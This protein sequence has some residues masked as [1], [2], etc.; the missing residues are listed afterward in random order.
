MHASTALELMPVVPVIAVFLSVTGL[1]QIPDERPIRTDLSERVKESVLITLEPRPPADRFR[2][3]AETTGLVTALLEGG[4]SSLEAVTARVAGSPLAP[5]VAPAT[6]VHSE[7]RGALSL[8]GSPE[9]LVVEL[10]LCPDSGLCRVILVEGTPSRPDTLARE[11]VRR[12]ARVVDRRPEPAQSW[13]EPVSRDAYAQ[14]LAGRSAAVFYGMWPPTP[15]EHRGDVL[16]DPIARA[17]WLDPTMAVAQWIAGRQLL[18]EGDADAAE[19]AMRRGV[20]HHPGTV[21]QLAHGTLLLELGAL[22]EA[23]AAWEALASTFGDDPRLDFAEIEAQRLA[24]DL[25]EAL[26]RLDALPRAIQDAPRALE[27]R[28][29]IAMARADGPLPD[30]LLARWQDLAPYDPEPVRLRL[31]GLI[32]QGHPDEALALVPELVD[33]GAGDEAHALEVALAAELGDWE[34]S[35]AAAARI[36]PS[37]ADAI[38]ALAGTGSSSDVDPSTPLGATVALRDAERSLAERD[39]GGALTQV[40]AVLRRDPENADALALQVDILAEAQDPVALRRARCALHRVDP[41]AVDAPGSA[42]AVA[43]SRRCGVR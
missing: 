11:L 37:L 7:W 34:R 20:A 24:D 43:L 16:R 6:L 36:S 5:G 12:A 31:H 42:A 35:I 40:H 26:R 10:T 14:L 1:W 33:R 15:P 9:A 30:G 28:V 27:L 18:A 19:R 21:L 22:S 23:R 4:L 25:D 3:E 17:T 29:R 41:G 8:Q 2:W 39:P 32:E 38:R 13:T